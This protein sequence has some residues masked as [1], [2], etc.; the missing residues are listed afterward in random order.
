MLGPRL[1]FAPSSHAVE[2]ARFPFAI[3]Q[4]LHLFEFRFR[5]FVAMM[6]KVVNG[7][8]IGFDFLAFQPNPHVRYRI[9]R[10]LSRRLAVIFLVRSSTTAYS[11]AAPFGSIISSP[12]GSS[13]DFSFS[14][15]RHNF[16]K[17]KL[18]IQEFFPRSILGKKKPP[19]RG[20][21]CGLRWLM[22][23]PVFVVSEPSLFPGNG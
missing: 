6:G 15:E 5:N 22:T 17:L 19:L 13:T 14:T 4:E 12:S 8:G 10:W 1:H 7:E 2:H 9:P 3:T 16:F 11:V 21:Y 20:G 23:T 18:S